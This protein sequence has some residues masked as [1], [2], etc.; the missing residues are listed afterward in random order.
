M[1]RGKVCPS[2]SFTGDK[3]SCALVAQLGP[4]IMGS[5]KGCCMSAQVVI[6]GQPHDFASLP[7]DVKTMCARQLR[8]QRGL[9]LDKR[10][11]QPIA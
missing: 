10:T 9:V 11:L 4:E 3:S 6:Q 5:G 7:E 1:P 8:Q 2:L